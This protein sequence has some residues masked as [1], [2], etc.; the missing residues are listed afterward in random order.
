[1]IPGIHPGDGEDITE[2][3]ILTIA[4][5]TGAVTTGDT[6]TDTGIAGTMVQETGTIMAD[7]ITGITTDTPG[8]PMSPMANPKDQ[9]TWIPGT[10]A[11]PDLR[12]EAP[13]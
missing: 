7:W 13:E 9:H 1:M 5:L 11:V 12:K 3:I 4:A 10:E 2:D 8:L 6:T